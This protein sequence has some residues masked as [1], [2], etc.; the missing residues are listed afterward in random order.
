MGIQA[1]ELRIGNYV[2]EKGKQKQVYSV[3][4]HNAKDYSKVKPIPLTEDWLL[5][6]GF[7]T[8]KY[9]K[10]SLDV[11]KDKIFEPF[12]LSNVWVCYNYHFNYFCFDRR[13]LHPLS[14][15]HEEYKNHWRHDH[16][17]DNLQYVHQVQNLYFAL[18]GEELK[19]KQTE[20]VS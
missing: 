12:V 9:I 20:T 2:I 4:N 7:E 19:I 14:H 1:S 11:F 15:L 5:K 16:K 6:F 10:Y 3:S 8:E 17:S 18:T 13:V